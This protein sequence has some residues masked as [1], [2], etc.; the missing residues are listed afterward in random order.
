M[1]EDE[2]D[3]IT[4]QSG[5]E[6]QTWKGW[7]IQKI[8]NPEVSQSQANRLREQLLLDISIA[9]THL[10]FNNTIAGKFLTL[11]LDVYL[12]YIWYLVLLFQNCFGTL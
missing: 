5:S 11:F 3:V 7:I 4:T 2:P 1:A 12:V 9:S 8:V 6:I 10:D